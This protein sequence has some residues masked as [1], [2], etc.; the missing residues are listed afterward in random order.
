MFHRMAVHVHRGKPL[1]AARTAGTP[2][3]PEGRFRRFLNWGH[4]LAGWAQVIGLAVII[5]G[6][7]YTV[8]PVY[9]RDR[10]EEDVS[11]AELDLREVKRKQ[12]AA[13]ARNRKLETERLDLE[14]SISG[15][16]QDRD[17][18]QAKVAAL[19][20]ESGRLEKE[21]SKTKAD[22][23]ESLSATQRLEVGNFREVLSSHTSRELFNLLSGSIPGDFLEDG[24]LKRME[25]G[26]IDP[27]PRVRAAILKIGEH[28]DLQSKPHL[29]SHYAAVLERLEKRAAQG[30]LCTK[31]DLA[32]W[33]DAVTEVKARLAILGRH[34]TDER[35]RRF[36][37]MNKFSKGE[38]VR[39][40]KTD[41]WKD[42]LATQ[43][44][45]CK[46]FPE[47]GAETGF[48]SRWLNATSVC[49]DEAA[50]EIAG[51]LGEKQRKP[52]DLTQLTP[53]E[54]DKI[55][56]PLYETYAPNVIEDAAD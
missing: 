6:Y 50:R 45:I 40:A 9:E 17:D 13:M 12:E 52:A 16:R 51:I 11:R 49:G 53:P 41:W 25:E 43:A 46:S 44:R 26:W 47:I 37:D 32:A 31:P 35:M 34:C 4:D 55:M 42:E 19:S 18:S 28:P 23:G 27:L 2:L 33:A 14:K 8:R 1:R 54:P 38:R 39:Y 24:V 7:F 29:A 10:L 21:L 36:A 56:A 15:L 30:P 20:V 22:L 3:Q 48:S 5:F